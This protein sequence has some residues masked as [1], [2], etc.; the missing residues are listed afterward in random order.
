MVPGEVIDAY[1]ELLAHN[2]CAKDQ[3]EGACG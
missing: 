1:E 3:A 2:G